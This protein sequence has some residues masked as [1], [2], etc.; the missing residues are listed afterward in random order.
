M[1]IVNAP[2]T[3]TVIWAV[4]KAWL[5]EKTRE[6][7]QIKGS[8]YKKTLLKY[9]DED[10]LPEFLG[11]TNKAPLDADK[12]PWEDFEIVDG[13]KKE[14]VVGVKQK[15]T[16]KFI[17]L[18]EVLALPNYMIGQEEAPVVENEKDEEFAAEGDDQEE[19]KK[20]E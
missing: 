15:S 2:K 16:G 10:Q 9:V 3:F 19:E 17:S 7:I 13:N 4:I 11:G 18:D 12:G 20:Q 5:D 1:V 14:D 6:K 8:S